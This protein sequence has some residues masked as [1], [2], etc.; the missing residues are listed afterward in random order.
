MSFCDVGHGVERVEGARVYGSRRGDA[1]EGPQ[2]LL[3]VFLNAA[4]SASG[5]I[6]MSASVSIFLSLEE[7]S[8]ASSKAWLTHACASADV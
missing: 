8:P 6:R 3:D 4:A 7:P 5:L 2:S 1:D